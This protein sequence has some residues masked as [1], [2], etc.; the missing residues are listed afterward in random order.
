MFDHNVYE[1][2]KVAENLKI[3]IAKR[4]SSDLTRDSCP[5]PG[6][7]TQHPHRRPRSVHLLK[8]DTANPMA[9]KYQAVMGTAK[10]YLARQLALAWLMENKGKPTLQERPALTQKGLS[11]SRKFLRRTESG[12]R[13]GLS[14]AKKLAS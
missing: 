13:P 12:S 6:R 11:L 9:D 7:Q 4:F 10:S 2:N 14:K 8:R 3:E 5:E 1:L